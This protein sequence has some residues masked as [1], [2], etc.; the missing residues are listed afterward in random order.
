MRVHLGVISPLRLSCFIPPAY[1]R[2]HTS[3]WM[4]QH[5]GLTLAMGRCTSDTVRRAARPPLGLRSAPARGP[6]LLLEYLWISV[7]LSASHISPY[8]LLVRDV[9][10]PFHSCPRSFIALCICPHSARLRASPLWAA[11]ASALALASAYLGIC[12]LGSGPFPRTIYT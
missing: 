3:A 2:P 12:T 1:F 7:R 8:L 6:S 10:V 4:L 5:R 9:S 11:L